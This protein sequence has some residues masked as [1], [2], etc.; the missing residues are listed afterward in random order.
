MA[1]VSIRA[2]PSH[3]CTRCRGTPE[4]MACSPKPW[5]SPFG[6][7]INRQSALRSSAEDAP[8][9]RRRLRAADDEIPVCPG[10]GVEHARWRLVDGLL[11]ILVTDMSAQGLDVLMRAEG[12]HMSDE[13]LGI[14]DGLFGSLEPDTALRHAPQLLCQ[15]DR[16]HCPGSRFAACFRT[17]VSRGSLS[18]STAR[19]DSWRSFLVAAGRDGRSPSPK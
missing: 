14:G 7:F 18:R 3:R 5:R 12:Q 10:A 9:H 15:L 1:V 4:R 11:E 2:W 17:G 6:W 8:G 16:F 13:V 19:T